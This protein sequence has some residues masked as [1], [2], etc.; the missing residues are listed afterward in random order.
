MELKLNY[1]NYEVNA[2]H[3]SVDL[4]SVYKTPTGEMVYSLD[5]VEVE[6]RNIWQIIIIVELVDGFAGQ[7]TSK[8][9][10]IRT[11]PKPPKPDSQATGTL[12]MCMW[13]K[14]QVKLEQIISLKSNERGS[15]N[16]H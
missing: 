11:K 1:E 9:F 2:V 7:F 14:V 15:L 10:R 13:L 16:S 12:V 4:D 6:E 3:F 5:K 8:G